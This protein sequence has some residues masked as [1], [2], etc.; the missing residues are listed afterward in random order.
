MR[1]LIFGFFFFFFLQQKGECERDTYHHQ[2]THT[3][4]HLFTH[5]NSHTHTHLLPSFLHLSYPH[6]S[7]EITKDC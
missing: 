7:I 5:T 3:P 1:H 6:V 2:D 4:T